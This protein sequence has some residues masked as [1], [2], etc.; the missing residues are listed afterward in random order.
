MFIKHL[1]QLGVFVLLGSHD[2]QTKTVQVTEDPEPA[3]CKTQGFQVLT[4]SAAAY[5]R[6]LTSLGTLAYRHGVV[7]KPSGSKTT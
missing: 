4:P 5:R 1:K 3:E 2:T 6:P 7:E